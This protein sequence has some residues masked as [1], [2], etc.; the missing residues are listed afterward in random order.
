M[1]LAVV[2]GRMRLRKDDGHLAGRE[3][4]AARRIRVA[5]GEAQGPAE[6]ILVE[7]QRLVEIAHA[8]NEVIE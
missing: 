4:V 6:A 3:A 8:Q 1:G 7:R 5:P 2:V